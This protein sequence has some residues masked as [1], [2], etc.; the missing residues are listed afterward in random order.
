MAWHS[1]H[2]TVT[3]S[4]ANGAARVG[5]DGFTQFGGLTGCG[6]TYAYAATPGSDHSATWLDC[7]PMAGPLAIGLSRTIAQ[8]QHPAGGRR[9]AKKGSQS[10]ARSDEE[11]DRPKQWQFW[12]VSHRRRS[13]QDTATGNGLAVRRVHR[14]R[15]PLWTPPFAPLL[16]VACASYWC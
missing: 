2:R 10:Q 14:S 8:V 12:P 6:V 11:S 4:S 13:L 16:T 3:G 15:L 5:Y 7:P 9:V 1:R